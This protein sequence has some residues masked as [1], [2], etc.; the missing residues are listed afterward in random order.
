MNML[1]AL[2]IHNTRTSTFCTASRD[3]RCSGVYISALTVHSVDALFEIIALEVV[4]HFI[5]N[6]LGIQCD[7]A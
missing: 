2:E 5:A 6:D 1:P 4:A 3:V 7:E